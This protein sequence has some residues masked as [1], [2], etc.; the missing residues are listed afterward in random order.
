ML[1]FAGDFFRQDMDKPKQGN[2]DGRD[3]EQNSPGNHV[4]H[5][6]ERVALKEGC[7][8]LEWIEDGENGGEPES[9]VWPGFTGEPMMVHES[10]GCREDLMEFLASARIYLRPRIIHRI[11]GKKLLT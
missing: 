4:G 7:A 2:R 1:A 8:G 11:Y 3:N 5:G 9:R 10:M 6:V